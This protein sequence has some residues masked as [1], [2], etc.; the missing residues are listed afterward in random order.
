MKNVDGPRFLNTE[1]ETKMG[2]LPANMRIPERAE[3]RNK[4]GNKGAEELLITPSSA[5]N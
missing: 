1:D 5:V 4:N 2:G 3:S